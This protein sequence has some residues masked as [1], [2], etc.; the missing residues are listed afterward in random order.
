MH[1][2][3]A[4]HS[5]WLPQTEQVPPLAPQVSCPD[6]SHAPFEQQP[7]Q[8]IP[9]QLQ[10]P[11]VQAWPDA[12]VPQAVPFMPQAAVLCWAARTHWVPSQQPPEQELGVQTQVPLV[13][14]VCPDPHAEHAAPPIPHW[15]AACAA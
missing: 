8:L 10:A 13:P 2:P 14:Q 5:C 6:V 15:P 3:C 9:P 11:A 4:L 12:Q 7:P 1:C